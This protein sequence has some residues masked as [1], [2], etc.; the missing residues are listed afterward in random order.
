MPKEMVLEV[1]LYYSLDGYDQNGVFTVSG[2]IFTEIETQSKIQTCRYD[3][4][5]NHCYRVHD[6]QC[7]MQK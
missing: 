3:D 5:I 7:T 4:R 1:H 6:A 2:S